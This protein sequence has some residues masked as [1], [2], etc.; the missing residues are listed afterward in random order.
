MKKHK[1]NI[2]LVTGGYSGEAKISIQS[3]TQV[4]K[5]IDTGKFNVYKVIIR[6][7]K[8]EYD[9]GKHRH[10]IDKNDFSAKVK[11]RKIRFDAVFLVLHGSPGEDGHL[12]GYFEMIGMPCTSSNL[13]TSAITFNKEVCKLVLRKHNIA[14][15]ESVVLLKD[16]LKNTGE[17]LNKVGLP[18][19]I[20]PNNGGSSI[21]VSKVA[22]KEELKPALKKAFAEDDEI[23]IE[24]Y[25]SGTEIT[26]GVVNYKGKV[27]ALAVTEIVSKNH[28]FDF[29]AKYE[30]K[31]TQEI[32]P[33][34]ISR[35][36]Y[37]ECMRLSET[38]YKLLRCRGMIRIDYILSNN[39][40]NLLEVN[41]IPGLTEK[42]L[43]P[44]QAS[45]RG[46]KTKE[47]FSDVIEKC[48]AGNA[49]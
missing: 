8:W 18:C 36:R 17:I 15:A 26:C 19:F 47:L 27:C 48:L 28:F 13:I 30:S 38:I 9:D 2:A 4:M 16:E 39:T 7:D 40:L 20:K 1:P 3:A 21:G 46:I 12:Q 22:R 31:T 33:A 45:Y 5:N 10:A 24:K 41:T 44:Q 29:D 37:D 32:T 35:T 43:L 14:M 25:I 42:S 34:R 6:R 49:R 11:G 23:I